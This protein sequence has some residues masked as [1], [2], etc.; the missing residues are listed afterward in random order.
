VFVLDASVALAWAFGDESSAIADRARLLVESG[1][2][3]VPGLWWFELRNVLL[4]GE[5]RRRIAGREVDAFLES[6]HNLFLQI[7][8]L[9]TDAAIFESA[10]RWRLTIYDAAYLELAQRLKAPLATLD[11]QLADAAR[12]AGVKSI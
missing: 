2:A 11:R 9:P 6:L 12:A 1:G 8:P 5:R 10:R 3:A 7:A 4:Q